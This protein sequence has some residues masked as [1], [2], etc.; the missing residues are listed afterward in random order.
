MRFNVSTMSQPAVLATLQG[1][2]QIAI[3]LE[4]ATLPPYLC[5]YWSI[6]P[7]VT[8]TGAKAAAKSVL[9]VIRGALVSN[10]VLLNFA[11]EG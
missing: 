5:A 1:D 8:S 4:Q 2:L 7:G 9:T 10:C 6:K 11:L 3:Q